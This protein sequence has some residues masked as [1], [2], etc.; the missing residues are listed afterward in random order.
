M[1]SYSRYFSGLLALLVWTTTLIRLLIPS[2]L[3]TP[4]SFPCRLRLH[5]LNQLTSQHNPRD[6]RHDPHGDPRQHVNEIVAAASNL[7]AFNKSLNAPGTA[8]NLPV[9]QHGTSQHGT[10]MGPP[11]AHMSQTG[12]FNHTDSG[13][14]SSTGSIRTGGVRTM[15]NVD[16]GPIGNIVQRPGQQ[17]S[18]YVYCVVMISSVCVLVQFAISYRGMRLASLT[19]S[20]ST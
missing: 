14:Q 1:S 8:N 9:S 11:G 5:E 16:N 19:T 10:N 3:L 7:A 20:P 6:P 18:Q 15:S 17:S 13:Y 4:F 2:Y 12:T